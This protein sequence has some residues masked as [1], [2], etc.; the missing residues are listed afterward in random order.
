[1]HTKTAPK[2]SKSLK[3]FF[4]YTFLV[5]FVIGVSLAIKVFFVIQQSTYNG[6][7]QFIVAVTKNGIVEDVISFQPNNL[8]ISV[9]QLKGKPVSLTDLGK[10][11]GI[12]PN[13]YVTA[14]DT[15]PQPN[16]SDTLT[17][18]A[19]RYNMLKT[20][21]TLIDLA[22]LL[23]FSKRT[24]SND[25]TI[26]SVTLSKNETAVDETVKNLFV[27]E[28][29]VADNLSIQIINA[30]DKPGLGGRL[31]T[32]I[33]NMGGNVISLSTSHSISKGSKI[34]YFGETSYTLEKLHSLLGFPIKKLQRETLGDI[35]ITI[36]E[37]DKESKK[38]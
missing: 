36:G 13:A 6:K 34:E 14:N 29:I 18:V 10:T 37:K 38:F 17:A 35:V 31:E 7:N 21:L 27:D 19:L 28:G 26:E 5:L 25:I 22:R 30:S 12:I 11:V 16:P 33:T 8:T 15:L 2:E 9:L 32:V 24:S 4:L 23:I 20:N 3:T 1:M